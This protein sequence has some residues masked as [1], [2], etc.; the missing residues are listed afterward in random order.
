[1]KNCSCFHSFNVNGPADTL[2]TRGLTEYGTQQLPSVID[3]SWPGSITG[4]SCLTSHRP[5]IDLQER[6]DSCVDNYNHYPPEPSMTKFDPSHQADY[7][8]ILHSSFLRS[9]APTQVFK[10]AVDRDKIMCPYLYETYKYA[11]NDM[12]NRK[13]VTLTRGLVPATVLS[14]QSRPVSSY[15]PVRV[16]YHS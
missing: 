15:A 11:L 2:S 12:A 16:R 7:T 14:D 3:V 8:R 9:R 4:K 10:L 13:I 5:D 6:N 1:M